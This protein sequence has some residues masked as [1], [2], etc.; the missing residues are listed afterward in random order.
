MNGRLGR[1]AAGLGRWVDGLGRRV[2]SLFFGRWDCVLLLAL[3]G[4]AWPLVAERGLIV[5]AD[6]PAWA[7]IAHM[8]GRDVLPQCHWFWAVPF[9]RLNAGEILGQPYSLSIIVPWLLMR[10][11]SPEWALKLVVLAT[12][13]TVGF[14]FYCFTAPKSSRLAACLG[15]YLCVLDNLW[16]INFGMWYNSLSIGLA[17][18]FFVALERF[19]E[20]RRT[21]AW[22]A[23]VLL[24]ALTILAHPVGTVMALAGWL[25]FFVSQLLRN[26]RSD[27]TRVLLVLSIPVLGIGMALGQVLGTLVGSLIGIRQ[28]ASIQYNPFSM[29]GLYLSR[30]ILLVSAYGL[31]G[32]IRKR[33]QVLW[34]I[35]PPLMLAP[36]LYRN[37]IAALPF[38]FPLKSGL[39]GFAYRFMLVASAAALVL[40]ALGVARLQAALRPERRADLSLARWILCLLVLGVALLGLEQTFAYQAKTLVGESALADHRDFMAL[41]DWID[42]NIDHEAERV[43]VE[44]TFG[45]ERDFSLDPGNRAALFL[46]RVLGR[47]STPFTHYMSLLSLRTRCQQIN[48]F[49]VYQNSFNE[50]YCGNGRRLF[51]IRPEDLTVRMLRERLWALNCRHIV[52]FSDSMRE[53]LATIRFL[54]CSCRFGRFCVFTWSDMPPHYAWSGE[55]SLQTIPATRL[56]AIHY[57]VDLPRV[58]PATVYLSLQYHANWKAY[59]EGKPVQVT[60][61]R[62]LMR[63]Q[64]PAG[65]GGNLQVCYEVRRGLPLGAAAVSVVIMLAVAVV[66]HRRARGEVPQPRGEPAD[67]FARAR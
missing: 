57:L 55:A 17:F 2:D 13:L 16:N 40:F 29:L 8:L 39:M 44:D 15:G 28:A 6:Y 4:L 34:L 23:A 41:C 32:A 45:R 42:T 58:R 56:S 37:W 20:S 26:G 5:Q 61:W 59:L 7:A 9:P 27:P 51:N 30:S 46:L 54:R 10:I 52:S 50:Q 11:M 49:P 31:A 22:V 12:Y 25:G 62:G 18:F 48:G 65:T 66:R 38:A 14:G 1:G 33:Q 47:N 3:L 64:I 63:L 21:A 35:L 19:A 24:L 43:Y 53:F 36:V 67:A 60:P